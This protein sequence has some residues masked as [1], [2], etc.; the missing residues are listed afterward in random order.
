MKMV[1]WRTVR[2]CRGQR[3]FFEPVFCPKED[4]SPQ[5]SPP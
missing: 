1:N 4:T 3:A 2:T 5:K